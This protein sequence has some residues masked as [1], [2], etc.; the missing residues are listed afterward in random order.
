MTNQ[1]HAD[2][3]NYYHL[4]RTAL[5]ETGEADIR[6]ARMVW[7][8]NSFAAESA[9]HITPVGAYKLLDSLLA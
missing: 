8:A 1:Y 6:H 5:A 2:L 9:R 4:A 3:I 7:A